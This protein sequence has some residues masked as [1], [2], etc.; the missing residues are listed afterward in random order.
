ML[1]H[2]VG[3]RER[4]RV[5]MLENPAGLP[6]YELLEL[7]LGTVIRRGDTKPL[8]KELLNCFGSLR[9]VLDAKESE[10]LQVPGFGPSLGFFWKLLREIMTRHAEGE[11]F[12]R[13][14][15]CG[16]KQVAEIARKRLGALAHE[17]IWA[18]YTDGQARLLAFERVARGTFDAASFHQRDVV[19]RAYELRAL[20]IILVHNHPG[21]NPKPSGFDRKLTDSVQQA[22]EGMDMQLLDH[23]IVTDHLCYSFKED[24]L[25]NI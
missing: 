5:R 17:E 8:S 24:D 9:G 11:Y 18:A 1:K 23:V 13:E 22:A 25:I 12:R 3:H 16:P 2:Q 7:L 6:D 10:L 15:I 20:G 4:L 14:T 21:G 19:G